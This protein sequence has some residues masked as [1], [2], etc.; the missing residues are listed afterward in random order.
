MIPED[1]L[2]ISGK[3]FDDIFGRRGVEHQVG[4][5]KHGDGHNRNGNE[6]EN[7]SKPG[8]APSTLVMLA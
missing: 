1:T 3:M 2:P 5:Q 7:Q 8:G 4:E 6:G